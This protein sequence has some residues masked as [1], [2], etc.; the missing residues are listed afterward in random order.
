MT[1]KVIY[2]GDL[3]TSCKH[4]MSEDV[5][6]TDAPVDNNG[7]GQAFSPTDTVATSLAS[8]MLTIMGIKS[9]DLNINISNSEANVKKVMAS[10]PRRIAEI[11]IDFKMNI[12][13]NTKTQ[14]ILEKA[15]L[16]CP[17]MYSIHPDIQKT[18]NFNWG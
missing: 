13:V 7:L 6:I 1:S 9:I 18:I 4:I 14:T 2:L 11:H 10:Q 8:C 17:V 15:A 5:F 16:T 3:R 12:K